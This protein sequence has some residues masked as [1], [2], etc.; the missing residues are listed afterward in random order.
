MDGHPVP[1]QGTR[2]PGHAGSLVLEVNLL[3][4]ESSLVLGLPGQQFA[5]GRPGW[6]ERRIT[7][8]GP[9]HQGS[10]L[11]EK[12]LSFGEEGIE[13]LPVFT[14]NGEALRLGESQGLAIDFRQLLVR[15]G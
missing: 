3:G 2:S 1:G 13:A 14:C 6:L 15:H 10:G 7:G 11:L 4:L 9:C 12:V 5:Q 8:C